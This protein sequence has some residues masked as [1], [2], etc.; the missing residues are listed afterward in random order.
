M[1]LTT[2][3]SA[4]VVTSYTGIT[5]KQKKTTSLTNLLLETCLFQL[6][7]LLLSLNDPIQEVKAIQEQSKVTI[8][9][10]NVFLFML[11]KFKLIMSSIQ[12]TRA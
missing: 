5:Q 7:T 2:K 8:I 12:N 3:T 1:L 4:I 11:T 9:T 6:N 10:V